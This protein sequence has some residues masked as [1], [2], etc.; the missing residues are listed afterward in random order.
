MISG[1]ENINQSQE[2]YF[3][4]IVQ[5]KNIIDNDE[6][7]FKKIAFFI[8]DVKCFWLEKVKHY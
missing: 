1:L 6:L 7:N 4:L 3:K 5:Y 2:D 8:D